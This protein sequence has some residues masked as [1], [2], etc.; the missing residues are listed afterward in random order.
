MGD[1]AKLKELLLPSN[2]RPQPVKK[3][4]RFVVWREGGSFYTGDAEAPGFPE[5][6]E[7]ESKA[8]VWPSR[9]GAASRAF[10]LTNSEAIC[11]ATPKKTKP[12]TG[13]T[14]A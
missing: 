11:F 2:L 9:S 7:D 10:D 1:N 13:D 8:A 6:T 14:N 4:Q 12:Q 3:G 5:W